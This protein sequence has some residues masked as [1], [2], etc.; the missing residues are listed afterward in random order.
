M[1]ARLKI[2]IAI[3]VGLAPLIGLF[4]I[5]RQSGP[6]IAETALPRPVGDLRT[7][8]G[9]FWFTIEQ[10]RTDTTSQ[11][12]QEAKLR[13]LLQERSAEEIEEFDRMFR[14][15]MSESY[16]WDLWGAAYVI[17]GGASDDGFEY[18]RRWLI[19]NG[20]HFYEQ[21]VADPESLADLVPANQ[22]EPLEFEGISYVAP[23]IWAGKTG[24]PAAAMPAGEVPTP[25]APSG[26]PFEEDE[27]ALAK[28]Y[29]R[30]WRRF[31]DNPLS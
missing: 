2:L 28:R 14:A 11:E 23:E 3:C 13:A 4:L 17:H 27:A 15:R 25:S 16:S 24:R 8:E 26:T 10:S 6:A 12:A 7:P 30:L 21:A 1:T 31:G 9:Q 19:S 29:P 18:F 22:K 5:A 20:R